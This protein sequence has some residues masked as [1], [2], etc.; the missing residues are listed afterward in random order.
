ML[1]LRLLLA[2]VF[3]WSGWHKALDPIGFVIKVNEYEILPARWVEPFALAL[4]WAMIVTSG[5]LAAGLL[6]RPA[7]AGQALMLLSFIVAVS[8]NI[9]RDRVL[10]CGCFSE[11]GSQIGWGLV[12][13]DICLMG[14]AA[15][16][17]VK[18]AGRFSVDGAI[19]ARLPW[20][21]KIVTVEP[22][23]K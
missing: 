19:G 16:V 5:L 14:L 21:R 10:G 18:G 22:P 23:E 7:A 2:V 8:V 17:A 13:Q 4:P 12:T 3:I 6:T 9:Y 20:V 15:L 11:Q 1:L